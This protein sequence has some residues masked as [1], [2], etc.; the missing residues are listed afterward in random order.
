MVM[1]RD[2]NES[3][4]LARDA[5]IRALFLSDY[6]RILLFLRSRNLNK[7]DAEEILQEAFLKA[8]VAIR[9]GK[10][11]KPTRAWI[12]TIV[13]N[14]RKNWIRN[15]TAQKR[16][17]NL[18]PENATARRRNGN[19]TLEPEAVGEPHNLSVVP[20]GITSPHQFIVNKEDIRRLQRAT[21]QLPRKMRLCFVMYFFHDRKYREI[22]AI[23]DVK[24]DTVKSQINQARKKIRQYWEEDVN[25]EEPV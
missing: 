15:A 6:E 14:T 21:E 10:V 19:L 23:L 2:E 8:F 1:T 4:H 20:S 18:T 16:S 24:I 22:A 17:G 12:F 25:Q 9:S 7:S 13:D 5:D 11:Q 3:Y